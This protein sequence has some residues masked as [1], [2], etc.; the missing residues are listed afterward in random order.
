MPFGGRQLGPAQT[1]RND[2]LAAMPHHLEKGLVGLDN[3][4]IKVKDRDPDDVGVD[5]ASDLRLTLLK[6]AVETGVLQRD[7]RLRRQQ[8]QDR[9]SIRWER[10][11]GQC[12]FEV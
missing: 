12:V 1:T 6:I 9:D 10:M 11:R 3:A 8:F 4:T 2:I 7:R 5:Q